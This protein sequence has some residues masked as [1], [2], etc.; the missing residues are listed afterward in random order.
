M[1]T[2]LRFNDWPLA[3][4]LLVVMLLIT[5]IPIA[6]VG[7]VN[8]QNTTTALEEEI[9][10]AFEQQ[11]QDIG[12]VVAI[13]LDEQARLLETLALNDQVIGQLRE[14]N[15]SY[16]GNE[17]EILAEILELDELWRNTED[18]ENF[19]IR[20]T[21]SSEPSVNE[22]TP[23]LLN[24][25]RAFDENLEMFVTDIRGATVSST[26]RLSDY[27]QA[28]EEWWQAAYNEG[29]G[30]IYI[31]DPEFDDSANALAVLIAVPIFNEGG[32]GELLGIAR[33]TLALDELRQG[34]GSVSIGQTGRAQLLNSQGEILMDPNVEEIVPLPPN[35]VDRILAGSVEHFVATDE[36][37][38]QSI[39]GEAVIRLLGDESIDQSTGG[40]RDQRIREALETLD[41]RVVIREKASEALAPVTAANRLALVTGFVAVIVAGL[42]AF[43]LSRLLTKQVDNIQ[44]LFGEIGI[45][46]FDA[47]AEVVL[48]D[49][50]GDL[51]HALNTM[52]DNIRGLIQTREERDAIEAAI[53]RLQAQVADV[54]EGDLRVETQVTDDLTGPI[55]E[56]FNTMIY[57]LRE[58][59]GT[60]QSATLQVST[61]AGE[62][63]A[64]AE[65]LSQGSEAQASQIVDTSAAV[66][67][68]SVSIQE[69]SDNALRSADVAKQALSTAQHGAKSVQDTIDGMH[70]IRE[71]VQET[72]KRI[73]RLGESSQ[74][75]GE[76]VQLIRDIAKRT[77]ILALNA[78]LEAA[79][80]GEAG[81]GFAVV[82]EDVKRLS[83]RS[84][85]ATRQITELI[86]T[87]QT[88]TNEA[89]AAMEDSTQQVVDGSRLADQAGQSLDEIEQVSNQLSE[90]I[91]SISQ[92]AQQQARGSEAVALSMG[93]I[94]DVTQQTAAGAKETANALTY[95]T[96]LADELRGSTRTFKLPSGNGHGG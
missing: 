14:R 5:L 50:L 79:A 12:G 81:R 64:T 92:A 18:E 1:K 25:E 15:A 20:R 67:E 37:G 34:I 58:V 83:E 86:K 70:R 80:A 21:L 94:A 41:W 8:A 30:A 26:D 59:I 72:A 31:S 62:V 90:L 74:E 10:V 2:I 96:G 49:E 88:E 36:A 28:D 19:L 16:Q 23:I 11:A 52:F 66:E 84:A 56:A 91:I 87:I 69:V 55:A 75:I 77:S 38:E 32:Q 51:A 60:V 54:A 33:T 73:K 65:H 61:S 53:Q 45:G 43:G 47:R 78:S 4:K 44:A 3:I 6:V 76:I 9:G 57:Q 71:Q 82:A 27:Y 48:N 85:E 29:Q 89:V 24:F 39:F 7:F 17:D 13:F 63:R 46:N 93:E 42:A 68:M 35:L 22:I 40:L 95:L